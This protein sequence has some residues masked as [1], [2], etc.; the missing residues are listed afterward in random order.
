MCRLRKFILDLGF[1][2]QFSWKFVVCKSLRQPILGADF[3]SQHSLLVDSANKCLLQA[4]SQHT[5]SSKK[6]SPSFHLTVNNMM[7]ESVDIDDEPPHC[8]SVQH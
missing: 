4:P 5:H 7:N 3:L 8:A 6:V 2:K 1:S